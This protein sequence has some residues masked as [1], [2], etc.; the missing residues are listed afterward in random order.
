MKRMTLMFLLLRKNVK[1][2]RH[3]INSSIENEI[4]DQRREYI[5]GLKAELAK[6]SPAKYNLLKTISNEIDRFSIKQI[7]RDYV[8]DEQ[9]DM[10][11]VRYLISGTDIEVRK[12]YDYPNRY[13][14]MLMGLSIREEPKLS[15]RGKEPDQ[16]P[17]V[18]YDKI[19]NIH[20][21]I[22]DDK[23]IVD[24]V[25]LFTGNDHVWFISVYNALND[26]KEAEEEILRQQRLIEE[27]L[28][29]ERRKEGILSKYS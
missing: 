24:K 4:R 23:T 21:L 14:H 8:K 13:Q 18:I 29:E 20:F 1:Q 2:L 7:T 3:F 6:L 10:V 19:H 22:F 5:I 28:R 17:W 9:H 15:P 27:K 12:E 25:E 11:M 26:A 16:D